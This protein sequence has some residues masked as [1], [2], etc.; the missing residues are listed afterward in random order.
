MQN[1]P[2][3]Q[4]GGI[5]GTVRRRLLGTLGVNGEA[6]SILSDREI[7]ICG[8]LGRL[9]SVSLIEFVVQTESDLSESSGVDLDLLDS[10]VF[11]LEAGNSLSLEDFVAFTEHLLSRARAAD[12]PK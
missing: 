6:A 1:S 7:Y 11:D 10:E 3:P 9:D 8:P 5:A 2:T 12:R 4:D